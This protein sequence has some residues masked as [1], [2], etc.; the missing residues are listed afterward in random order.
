VAL[1]LS[2][3]DLLELSQVDAA[4]QKKSSPA[5]LIGRK[6]DPRAS[7][8]LR[9]PRVLIVEDTL[10]SRELY[11]QYLRQEGW[12]VG[13]ATNGQEALVLATTFEPDVIVMDLS[14]PVLDGIEATRLLKKDPR[15]R[16]IPIIAM[17][18]FSDAPKEIQARHA[19]C[20][21]FV[22]K[23]CM[24]D[25]LLQVLEGLVSDRKNGA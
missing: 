4:A 23:P 24:P 9:K 13:D 5:N 2:Q 6:A 7:G 21:M 18:A 11:A 3:F 20:E 14:M 25:H 22:A 17:T 19:G 16:H 12:E 15:T 10:D 8:K 1:D